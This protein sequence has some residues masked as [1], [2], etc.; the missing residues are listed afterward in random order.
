VEVLADELTRSPNHTAGRSED[1]PGY[2]L[3][4]PRV[5][6]MPRA[7][8]SPNDATTVGEVRQMF[9]AQVTGSAKRG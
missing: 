5:L 4:F 9:T 2:A 7:D 1:E 6:G 8:K 3:R